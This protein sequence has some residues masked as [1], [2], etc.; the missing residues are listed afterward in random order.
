VEELGL[1]EGIDERIDEGIDQGIDPIP[2]PGAT[3]SLA[4]ISPDP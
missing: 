1:D 3:T 4:L 2:R